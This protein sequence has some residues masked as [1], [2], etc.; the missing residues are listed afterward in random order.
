MVDLSVS[1]LF[2]ATEGI[3]GSAHRYCGKTV[4][5]EHL[6]GTMLTTPTSFHIGRRWSV[7]NE[8]RPGL[9]GG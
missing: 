8:E 4:V 3:G 7:S 5:S 6:D 1:V 2:A 9:D